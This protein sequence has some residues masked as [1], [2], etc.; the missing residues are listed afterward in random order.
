MWQIYGGIAQLARA[1]GSYPAGHKFK[2]YCRYQNFGPI[3]K[4]LRHHPFTVKSAVRICLGSPICTRVEMTRAFLLPILSAFAKIYTCQNQSFSTLKLHLISNPFRTRVEL[5]FF[6]TKSIF[7][8]WKVLDMRKKHLGFFAKAR[9]NRKAIGVLP[10]CPTK[11]FLRGSCQEH[12]G[13]N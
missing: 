9:K 3:V 10:H 13:I 2:S 7:M 4:R 1:I 8:P 12:H 11:M 5:T 6:I